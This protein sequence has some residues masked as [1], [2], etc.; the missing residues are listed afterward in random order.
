MSW[1]PRLMPLALLALALAACDM[2]YRRSYI[3]PH[4]RPSTFNYAAGGRDLAVEVLGNPTDLEP[5]RFAAAVVA[6]MQ[7]HNA[8]QPTHL[9]LTPGPTARPLYRVVVA[10]NPAASVGR[11]DLCRDPIDTGPT[12]DRI[13]VRAAFCQGA[14]ALTFVRGRGPADMTVD[15]AV[16]RRLMAGLA[17]E[18]L[19]RDNPERRDEEDDPRCPFL[20]SLCA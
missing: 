4:Y 14:Q 16:F 9:T 2:T 15:S 18:L 8:G 10:F 12:A 1:L 11:Y 19:P 13:V 3:W 6:A 20:P 17:R 5:A 7:G